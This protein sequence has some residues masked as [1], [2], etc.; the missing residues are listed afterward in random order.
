MGE[1]LEF[2]NNTDRKKLIKDQMQINT[3]RIL[4]G[5]DN[6]FYSFHNG[7]LIHDDGEKAYR[8]TLRKNI[9]PRLIKIANEGETSTFVFFDEMHEE[10]YIEITPQNL[11]D[12][13][14]KYTYKAIVDKYGNGLKSTCMHSIIDDWNQLPDIDTDLTKIN[15]HDIK[16]SK[17]HEVTI[18][19]ITEKDTGIK[20]YF[21]NGM[22]LEAIISYER[23]F[24]N[25]LVIGEKEA[26]KEINQ[27][28]IIV[29][30]ILKGDTERSYIVYEDGKEPTTFNE[31]KETLSHQVKCE[32]MLR[33]IYV[34]FNRC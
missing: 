13:C 29:D 25:G 3:F 31:E 8:T 24:Y 1:E 5:N 17:E 12:F 32:L 22:P 6:L 19:S 18:Q 27:I 34:N 26:K 20:H 33:K 14:A 30:E 16:I 7:I 2:L 10:K 4:K 23:I 9:I 11:K 15:P 21:L 28:E